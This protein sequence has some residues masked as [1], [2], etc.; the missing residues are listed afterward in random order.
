MPVAAPLHVSATGAALPSM[1][2]FSIDSRSS[3]L[4]HNSTDAPHSF[5]FSAGKAII[6][7]NDQEIHSSSEN[8]RYNDIISE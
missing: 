4:R 1:V 2:S 7:P 6:H 3:A 5:V 8:H